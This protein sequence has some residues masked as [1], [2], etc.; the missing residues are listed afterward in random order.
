[1]A[2][3]LDQFRQAAPPATNVTGWQ[4]AVAAAQELERRRSVPHPENPT[5]APTSP[6]RP[7]DWRGVPILTPAE[8][9]ARQE[10]IRGIQ[11]APGGG[12]D[13][14]G[15]GG[16]QMDK[17][18]F[19]QNAGQIA[20]EVVPGAG[21]RDLMGQSVDAEGN[22]YPSIGQN[23]DEGNYGMVGLQAAGGLA[24]AMYGAAAIPILGWPVA[25]AGGLLKTGIG[26]AKTAA[27]ASRGP[28]RQAM[29]EGIRPFDPY[30][31]IN[32][33]MRNTDLT[34]AE[35]G[36]GA[37]RIMGEDRVSSRLPRVGDARRIFGDPNA[38]HM[39]VGG[40]PADVAASPETFE[41]FAHN[42]TLG[43]RQNWPGHTNMDPVDAIAAYEQ[44]VDHGAGNL[45]WLYEKMD[46]SPML[47]AGTM[48]RM[49]KWYDGANRISRNLAKRY[50]VDD[51]RAAGVL[52]AMSP[53]MDWFKNAS[54][55]ERI[56]DIYH[57]QAG[58][59][60]TPEMIANID[61]VLPGKHPANLRK[62]MGMRF[63]EIPATKEGR[64]AKAGWIRL[65]DETHNPREFRSILPEGD[66]GDFVTN[67]DGSK[68][69]AAWGNG[70]GPIEKSIAALEANTIEELSEVLGQ[71]H[72]VR[73][74]F[75]NILSPNSPYRDKTM[76]TH[77]IAAQH[78]MPW[79]SGSDPV[80]ANF[81]S[82]QMIDVQANPDF[83]R[84]VPYIPPAK[85]PISGNMGVYGTNAG[86]YDV[87]ADRYGHLPR[88]FQSI[89]WEGVRSLF[90]GGDK[91]LLR[92]QA[93]AIW[94]GYE[95]GRYGINDAREKIFELANG[96]TPP[97]WL[98]QKNIIP[99]ETGSTFR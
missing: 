67:S 34:G 93:E 54:L 10:K 40:V 16:G 66:F 12:T 74:F 58:K 44:V 53:Q 11:A 48:G 39:G 30:L 88:Q 70:I 81:G 19:A 33:S 76:D 29:D 46:K 42:A 62:F 36:I 51:W 14:W 6:A 97:A 87:A 47:G 22:Y 38:V 60:M 35:L 80:A 27:R 91:K 17:G 7:T 52:A 63:D 55:G 79:G 9:A 73:S 85:D 61:D 71:N 24:D 82:G 94:R 95:Q 3:L 92:P 18:A 59:T 26:A 75:N 25:A 32:L 68:T 45:G 56:M 49:S 77:A 90:D 2:D 64:T 84:G 23:L 69:V 50:G 37:A 78:L 4:Q 43:P 72:K 20:S 15:Y 1:M 89:T 21:F 99:S 31:D 8:E 96:F 83:S 98:D 41:K 28:I 5:A 13:Y 65:Y 86:A 57:H